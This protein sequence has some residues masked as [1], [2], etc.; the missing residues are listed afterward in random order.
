MNPD[1]RRAVELARALTPSGLQQFDEGVAS[2]YHY[3]SGGASEAVVGGEAYGHQVKSSPGSNNGHTHTAHVDEAGNGLTSI[4][5]E[6]SHVVRSF[7]V[8]DYQDPSE[9]Y[10]HSHSGKLEIPTDSGKEV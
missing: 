8:S 5:D 3:Y 4:E 6:H 2:V 7:L 1:R 10:S 9:F